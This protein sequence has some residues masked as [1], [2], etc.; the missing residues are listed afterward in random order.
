MIYLKN[1]TIL[2]LDKRQY[3]VGF[4]GQKTVHNQ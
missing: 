3:N 1:L 2:N 4:S